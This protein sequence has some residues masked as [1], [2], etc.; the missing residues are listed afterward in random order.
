M[1]RDMVTMA[2]HPFRRCG[3]CA[4]ES[5]DYCI[6]TNEFIAEFV[7][8]GKIVLTRHC[9]IEKERGY[10]FG[11]VVDELTFGLRE[12]PIRFKPKPKVRHTFSCFLFALAL[13]LFPIIPSNAKSLQTNPHQ[14]KTEKTFHTCND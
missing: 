13:K 7:M 2:L 5:A 6:L 9:D 1:K 14:D 12:S 3:I 11:Y 8:G 4:G 10:V